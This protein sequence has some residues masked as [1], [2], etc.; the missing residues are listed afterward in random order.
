MVSSDPALSH[1]SQDKEKRTCQL[2]LPNP[3]NDDLPEEMHHPLSPY[4]YSVDHEPHIPQ[5]DEHDDLKHLGL[6]LP[7]PDLDI[8]NVPKH[9]SNSD[10]FN[11][12]TPENPSSNTRSPLSFYYYSV[13]HETLLPH[14]K[15]RQVQSKPPPDP[16]S[17]R[18]VFEKSL[19]VVSSVDS[20]DQGNAEPDDDDD[21]DDG[22]CYM[23]LDEDN[24]S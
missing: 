4:R 21:D 7:T 11:G 17:S 10:P 9:D 18:P 5:V 23:Y 20:G 14:D 13:D 3:L 2:L 19:L 8:A 1:A 15:Q 16:M 12:S 6:L 22:A 24:A